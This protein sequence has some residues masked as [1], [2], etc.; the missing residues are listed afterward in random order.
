MCYFN[1][2]KN[3]NYFGLSKFN[4]SWS[5]STIAVDSGIKKKNKSMWE[6]LAV[7]GQ[8]DCIWF[9][10]IQEEQRLSSSY[11]IDMKVCQIKLK[12]GKDKEEI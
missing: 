1:I 12:N 3:F 4:K 2:L 8:K 10:G 9:Q 6:G 5:L 11:I 7:L